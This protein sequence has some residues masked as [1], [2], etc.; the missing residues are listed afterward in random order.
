MLPKTST[1]GSSYF[2][3]CETDKSISVLQMINGEAL[4]LPQPRRPIYSPT[5][6]ES[7]PNVMFEGT[8]GFRSN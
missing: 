1:H 8:G 6:I 2:E 3:G 4:Q 7:V 5:D